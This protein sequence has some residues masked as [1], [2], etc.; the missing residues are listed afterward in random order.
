[1]ENINLNNIKGKRVLIVGMGKSGVAAIQA[2]LKLGAEVTVQDSK[3]AEDMDGQFLNFLAGRGLS[4]CLGK[5]PEDMG[6]FDMLILSPGVDPEMDFIEEAKSKGAEIVGELE[7][8]YRVARGS[9][10]AHNGNQWKDYHYYVSG[11]DLQE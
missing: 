6:A 4:L 8:A 1:M 2:M 3:N 7:I 5:T 10:V 11:R 9:F